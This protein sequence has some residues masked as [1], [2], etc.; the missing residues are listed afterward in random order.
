MLI[1]NAIHESAKEAGCIPKHVSHPK[2]FW[3][4][5]LSR[6]RDQKRFWWSIWISMGRPRSG[7]VYNIWKGLKKQFRRLARHNVQ[8]IMTRDYR[9]MNS[10]YRSRNMKS[11]WNKLKLHQQVRT[12]SHLTADN[13]AQFY[14]SVMSDTKDLNMEQLRIEQFVKLQMD[15]TSKSRNKF[16]IG[17]DRVMELVRLLNQGA[18]PGC[19]G[20]TSEHLAHGMTPALASA[21]AD[22][23]SAALSTAT[24]PQVFTDGVIIPIIK[25]ASCD[26]NLPVNYR[27]ITLSSAHSKLME[28]IIMPNT[29]ICDSQFG[30]R[31]RRGTTFATSVIHD[32]AAYFQEK[33]SPMYLCSLDAEKCFDSIWHDALLYKLYPV[34]EPCKWLFMSK[35]YKSSHAIVRWNGQCSFKFQMQRGMRQGSV[36]SPTL[37]NIFLDELLVKLQD[38]PHGVRVNDVLLNS[39]AYAD[40]VTVFSSSV[41]GLQKLID[42]CYSYAKQYRFTFG[43]KKSKCLVLGKSSLPQKPLWR[44]GDSQLTTE[45]DVGILG[46]TFNERLKSRLHVDNRV[47][48]CRRRMYGLTSI[49]MSYPGLGADVKTYLWNSIGGP[50][51]TYGLE[52]ISLTSADENALLSA[53]GT[54]IKKSIGFSKCSH[55]TSLL[56]AMGIPPVTDL[57]KR[58]AASLF[59]RIFQVSS[60]ARALQSQLLANF[61]L[62]NDTVK[63]SLLHRII[64]QGVSP[65]TLISGPP[66]KLPGSS[67]N[68][69]CDSL[70][71]LIN[72]DN[73]LKPYSDEYFMATLLLKAF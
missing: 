67:N 3:C 72:H 68:G 29:N 26:P 16:V 36:L 64:K 73:F 65:I 70:R 54:I 66:P 12:N 20:V 47:C 27:P 34:L 4:P 15:K 57:I 17:P 43:Q 19:D 18:A 61:I 58:N 45:S 30:F 50:T 59:H 14:Q 9:I 25:K 46:V 35:W 21:L 51:M 23:Y 42:T 8:N 62:K 22:V 52:S 32:C 28:L 56:Q 13:L 6:L 63:S 7:A 44:L 2:A 10:L 31:E 69:L 1:N 55:H 39:V 11:F 24:V 41:S 60:P 38:T 33:G 40:D 48:A 53:Q 49:G 5:E 37:F 71:L